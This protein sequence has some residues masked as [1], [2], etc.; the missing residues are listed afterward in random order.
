MSLMDINNLFGFMYD[1]DIGP[2]SQPPKHKTLSPRERDARLLR[3]DLTSGIRH[4][5]PVVINSSVPVIKP[6]KVDAE[7]V[8][9]Q[10]TLLDFDKITKSSSLDRIVSF[11]TNDY[12]FIR[13]MNNPAK[14]IPLLKGFR[15]V[16]TP[17]LSQ[18][19]NMPEFQRYAQNCWNKILAV[20]MQQ[21][22]VRIIYNV[23]W[24]L[25]DSYQYAF[26]GVPKGCAIAINCAGIKGSAMSMY[27]WRQG[28]AEALRQL[29]PS[30]ILRYGDKMPG[31]CEDLSV[32]FENH[33]IKRVR[34]G[35][36]RK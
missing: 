21:R 4:Y 16:V 17:D 2:T 3:I 29:A 31:E 18:S 13:I 9:S 25:P 10:K 36:K 30:L 28:Y 15:Y 27:L 35:G 22:G 1:Q 8:R 26:A 11:Y 19:I 34:D 20:Y 32:Y 24:S 14:Y 33:N 7:F 5:D 12:L 23:T 6:Y